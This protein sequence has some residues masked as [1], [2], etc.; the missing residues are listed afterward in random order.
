M[1]SSIKYAVCAAVFTIV[2]ILLGIGLSSKSGDAQDV[3][4]RAEFNRNLENKRMLLSQ[5]MKET[6]KALD[7]LRVVMD[8]DVLLS[9]DSSRWLLVIVTNHWMEM[10]NLC[11]I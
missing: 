8:K 10:K 2:G 4:V 9:P 6:K 7:K 3:E 1:K 11:S 5:M